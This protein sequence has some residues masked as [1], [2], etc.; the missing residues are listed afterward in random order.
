MECTESQKLSKRKYNQSSKGKANRKLWRTKNKEREKLIN[1][2]YE[3]SPKGLEKKRNWN[4][5]PK[6]KL[7]QE[8]YRNK[9]INNITESNKK[10]RNK[11]EVKERLKVINKEWKK[12]NMEKA[13]ETVRAYYQ[14][15]REQI[16]LKSKKRNTD[17]KI[18]ILTHYGNGKC[19]CVMCG[20]SRIDCLSVDHKK[21]DG[22][23]HRK[24]IGNG[25]HFYSWLIKNN[26]P[27]GYQTLCMN[28]Q[29][30]KR[31]AVWRG[32]PEPPHR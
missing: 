14:R 31:A 4:K 22:Y 19:A 9:H 13:R 2:R 18:R 25:V 12:N 11:P 7:A 23:K 3:T 10:W 21:N 1:K 17:R 27:E 30:V 5:S 8:K 16:N 26:Y 32:L 20:E 28:C 24:T 15:N 29:F 6:G